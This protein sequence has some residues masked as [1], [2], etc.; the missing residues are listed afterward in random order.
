MHAA[1]FCLKQRKLLP[2][3]L[4]ILMGSATKA[5]TVPLFNGFAHN[6]YVHKRPLFDALD[7]GFTHIEADVYLRHSKLLVAHRPPMLK[8][9]KKRRTIE[10][11]YLKPLYSRL[12]HSNGS[13][14]SPL[15]T[16]VLMI[17][18]K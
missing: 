9:L 2:I 6:D 18:I 13:L 7:N 17:D 10:G 8:F 11:L 15:D 16:I 14:Q 5:Q 12:S 4:L 3:I 1:K